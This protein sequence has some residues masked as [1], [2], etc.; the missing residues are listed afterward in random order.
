MAVTCAWAFCAGLCLPVIGRLAYEGQLPEQ[1]AAT[2]A[3]KFFMRAFGGTLGVLVAG[4][5]LE[6]AVAWG[7][8]FVRSSQML[9]QG[10]LEVTMPAVRDHMVRSG[11]TPAEAALQADATVGYWVHV[12]AQVIGFR[13]ALR[14]CAYASA[15]GLVFSLFISRRKETSLLDTDA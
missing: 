13:T 3:M 6:R 12:H 7:L 4:V 10:A 2:G 8:D 11:S 14:F 9:G 5:L 15:V 1:L